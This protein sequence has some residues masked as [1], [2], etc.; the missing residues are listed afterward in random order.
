MSIAI[1]AFSTSTIEAASMPSISTANSDEPNSHVVGERQMS[2]SEAATRILPRQ[3]TPIPTPVLTAGRIWTP[4]PMPS[5][6]LTQTLIQIQTPIRT[7]TLTATTRI[8][9]VTAS[10]MSMT[11]AG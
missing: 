6:T 1:L 2:R 8:Q 10:S 9:T 4:I 3:K 5:R 7:L 11:A